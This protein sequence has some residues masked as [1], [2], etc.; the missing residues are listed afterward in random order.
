MSLNDVFHC[1]L[2]N[3]VALITIDRP[4]LNVLPGEYYHA[5][6]NTVLGLIER[7]RGKGRHYHRH[8]QSIHLRARHKRHT[9]D[10]DP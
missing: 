8:E 9:S 7:Q 6:C 1:S 4:P 10:Q 2:E 5:L 3:R